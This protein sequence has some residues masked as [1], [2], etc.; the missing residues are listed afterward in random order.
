MFRTVYT[1]KDRE[2]LNE[3]KMEREGRYNESYGI[4]PKHIRQPITPRDHI[5]STIKD[6]IKLKDVLE[7]LL[8]KHITLLDLYKMNADNFLNVCYSIGMT[9]S[10]T[11]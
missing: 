4:Y 6:R 5:L 9:K 7:T 11:R 10:T 1:Q 8:D 3:A 2:Y